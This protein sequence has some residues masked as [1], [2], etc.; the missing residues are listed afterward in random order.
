M[1]RLRHVEKLLTVPATEPGA[2]PVGTQV[3]RSRCA[4]PKDRA[5]RSRPS[6]KLLYADSAAVIASIAAIWQSRV[7]DGGV[8]PDAAALNS[9]AVGQPGI[10][11]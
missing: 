5:H 1:C 9:A 4:R 3:E 7:I 10:S 11:T 6:E 2:T 8:S